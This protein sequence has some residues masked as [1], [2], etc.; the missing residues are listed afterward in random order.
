MAVKAQNNIEP[1][2]WRD[3]DIVCPI[4]Q[5]KKS[6]NIPMRIIDDSKA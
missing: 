5:I 4:C 1:E 2:V 3:I 6:I